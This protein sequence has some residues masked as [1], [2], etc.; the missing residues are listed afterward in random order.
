MDSER[1][2]FICN[3]S[4]EGRDVLVACRTTGEHGL[5]QE[6]RLDHFI[7]KTASGESGCWDF[8]EC[9]EIGRDGAE[10]PWR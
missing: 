2:S 6:C 4:E 5:V 1:R 9:E 3:E 7:V 10:F 8:N